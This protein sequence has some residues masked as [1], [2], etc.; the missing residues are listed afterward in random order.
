MTQPRVIRIEDVRFDYLRATIAGTAVCRAA[1]GVLTRRRLTIPGD[2]LW[3]HN[4]AVHA[5]TKRTTVG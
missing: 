5:L 4:Q 1:N 3:T 2:L